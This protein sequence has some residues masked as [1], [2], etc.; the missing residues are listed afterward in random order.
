MLKHI[1]Y[2][3]RRVIVPSIDHTWQLDLIDVSKIKDENDLH[4]YIL[5]CIDVFSKR[6]WS[7]PLLNKK[8]KTCS[9][10]FLQI[11]KKSR[12]KPLKIR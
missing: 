4:S 6:A 11:L 5:N 12:R 3:R 2:T 7:K 9:I 1:Q 10:A 8:A